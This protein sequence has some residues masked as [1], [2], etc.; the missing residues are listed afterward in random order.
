MLFD[1]NFMME[2]IPRFLEGAY[3]TLKVGVIV[4]ITS[5][6]VGIGNTTLLFLELQRIRGLIR[7][8]VEL[9]RNTPLLVQLF[10]LYFALP[11]IGIK[12]SSFATALVAMTFLGGGYMTETLRAGME[13][14]EQGQVE[15]GRAL[16]M[17]RLQTFRF[18]VLPQSVRKSMPALVGNFIFLLKETSIVSAIA[19]PELLYTATD[20]IATYYK[21]FEMFTLLALFYLLLILPLSGLLS[22]MERRLNLE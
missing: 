6:I 18:I 4:M 5:L 10:F 15:A 22:L 8:Y 12:M 9:A 19:V 14:V 21:T 16:G 2:Q 7:G 11:S 20:L 1:F 17:T 13:A 3:M